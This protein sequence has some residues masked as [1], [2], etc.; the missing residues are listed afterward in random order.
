[1]RVV[2]G[3]DLI[4]LL[5]DVFEPKAGERVVVLADRPHGALRDSP[6]WAERRR[7]AEEWRAGFAALGAEALP[8]LTYPATGSHNADLPAEG[9]L[10]ERVVRVGDVVLACDIAV[11]LTEFSAT[12]PLNAWIR[13]SRGRLRAASLPGVERR[14]EQ[15]A[16]AA[17]YAQVGRRARM[18]AERLTRAESAEVTFSTGHFVRFDLRYRRGYAD[19]GRCAPGAARA[20]NLPSGEAYVV[21]YEGERPG[22]PSRTEGVLP[23]ER[24]GETILLNVR[25]NRI[26]EVV[27][28]GPA[29]AEWRKFFAEDP[30]RANVAELGLGCNDRAVVTGNV[31]ED[32]KVGFH[33][34]YGRSEHLGGVTGAD[35]FLKP[36]H[37]VH[38]D[39]VYAPGC[40]VTVSLL[41]LI[42]PDGGHEDILREGVYCIF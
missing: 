26:R 40:P 11:A 33:W 14:M 7:M 20:I 21:P 17:D 3:F 29:A 23:V 34:A 16:L 4:R 30:A 28:K 36:E 25:D 10:G 15:T 32:E 39:L 37:V 6:A 38:Q 8:L 31:L 1:M 41:R 5:R 35:A 18:L 22:E 9:L 27:G 19:D 12:A 13:Q 2:S 24:G 42:Y